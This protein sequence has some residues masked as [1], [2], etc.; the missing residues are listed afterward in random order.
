MTPMT[1]N[2]IAQR[3]KDEFPNESVIFTMW[4][5]SSV[6]ALKNHEITVYT[7]DQGNV[8]GDNLDDCIKKVKLN[9]GLTHSEMNV[10]V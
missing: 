3:L 4:V 8:S 7:K 1:P 2:E 6:T 9:R 5:H 10:A